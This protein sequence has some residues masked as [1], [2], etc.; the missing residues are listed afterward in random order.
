MY[1]KASGLHD[2]TLKNLMY[3]NNCCKF[4]DAVD[5]NN[6]SYVLKFIPS[7]TKLDEDT[8]PF[9]DCFQVRDGA[10][11]V[12]ASNNFAEEGPDYF[13]YGSSSEQDVNTLETAPEKKKKLHFIETGGHP[14]YQNLGIKEQQKIRNCASKKSAVTNNS[15]GKKTP[16]PDPQSSRRQMRETCVGKLNIKSKNTGSSKIRNEFVCPIIET[17]HVPGLASILS[18]ENTTYPNNLHEKHISIVNPSLHI[19]H[20]S[21]KQIV[22][23][24]VPR[25]NSFSVEEYCLDGQNSK[26][27]SPRP[28]NH[29]NSECDIE[30]NIELRLLKSSMLQRRQSTQN[31]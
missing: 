23:T 29:A 30:S 17:N 7:D 2:Y 12:Y 13:T 22:K 5:E 6:T 16:N 19:Y 15:S 27:Y 3:E 24:P 21:H 31:S 8:L 9:I 14:K 28:L 4:Y 11:L 10:F 20:S 18:K 25:G 26:C 1:L